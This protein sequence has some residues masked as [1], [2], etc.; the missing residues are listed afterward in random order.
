MMK[1]RRVDL[2]EQ[3][4]KLMNWASAEE[5]NEISMNLKEAQPEGAT[6]KQDF[7]QAGT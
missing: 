1:A 4:N 2:L 6:E 5:L 3:M 7:Q